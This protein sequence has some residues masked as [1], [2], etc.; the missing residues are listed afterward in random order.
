MLP[1]PLTLTATSPDATDESIVGGKAAQLARLATLVGPRVPPWFVLPTRA[2]EAALAPSGLRATIEELVA[3]AERDPVRLARAGDEIR[4]RI[5][6]LAPIESLREEVESLVTETF[7]PGAFLAV[8]SSAPGEDTAGDSFAGLHESRLFVRGAVELWSAVRAVWASAF[9]Q[10]ALAY[11][12]ERR[13]PLER[14]GLAVIV[15]QMIDARSSGVLFTA[16]P[17]EQ[18]VHRLVLSALWGAGEGLVSGG[19]DADT[20]RI[21]KRSLAVASELAL[22]SEQLV[23]DREREQGLSRVPVAAALQT[24]PSVSVAEVVAAAELGRAL[25]RRFR[26]P[27]DLELAWSAD[28]ELHLLQARP[29]TTLH[30]LGPAAGHRLLW[31]N[32]NIVESYSGVTS[33]MTFSFIRRAYTIVY[34]NFA[35][36]MGIPARVVDEH[37]AVFAN[38]LGYI[39]G[40]VYY[41]LRNWYR[42]VQLFPG[43]E[44]NRQFME[45]M[46][47]VKESALFEDEPSPSPLPARAAP[48]TGRL[49]LARQLARTAW[50]FVRIR[51]IVERFERHFEAR[52]RAYAGVDF[53]SKALHELMQLYREMER[54]LLVEWRA[55]IVNDFFVMVLYGTLKKL[56]VDWCGDP[57]GALQNELL[58]GEGGIASTEPARRMMELAAQ[59]RA[60]PELAA[61]FRTL[62]AD[63]LAATLPGDPRFAGF[64]VEVARYLAQYGLRCM[65]EL[66]LEVPP[67]RDRP[68]FLYQ[69]V[70]NYLAAPA[71]PVSGRER[72]TRRKAEARAATELRARAGPL[73][74]IVRGVVFRRVLAGARLGVRNRENLRFA[75]TQVYGLLRDLLCA[76]GERLVEAKTLQRSQD[77]FYLT[78]DELWDYVQGTAVT[79]RLSELVELRKREIDGYRAAAG[80]ADRFETFGAV[81]HRNLFAARRTAAPVAQ[82][83]VLKGVGCCAGEVAGVVKLVRDPKEA[84]LDGEILAAERTDPGWV[85]LF[86]SAAGLLVERGSILSHSAIVAREMGLP[87]IVGIAGLT[88]AVPSGSRVRMDGAAGTVELLDRGPVAPAS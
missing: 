50:R 35:D 52:H 57:H 67:L 22:K 51:S 20:F 45:S 64:A 75:R 15:Q 44:R 17:V 16:D 33:P 29:I 4:E 88:R 73:S 10:R 12:A 31:D 66:K 30:E 21:D 61:L 7:T 6:A 80:P 28:G 76:A 63:E 74:A 36:V 25:E 34:R 1:L 37:S 19:F 46:M 69:M 81:Y 87:T 82:A 83:G 38:M 3:S 55:P 48:R 65:D 11:R 56:C 26:L 13:L 60:D 24:A 14:I 5:L 85:P 18:D 58:S 59:A 49:A 8:R 47:G 39:R 71:T 40:R 79:T 54:E 41:N 27:L 70:A 72:E 86:P 77:V 42:V 23:F 62:G 84:R 53:R 43:Y 78:L 9:S 68:A 32:W 2:F